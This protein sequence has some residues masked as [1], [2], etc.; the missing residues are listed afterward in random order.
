MSKSR[1]HVFIVEGEIDMPVRKLNING[2]TFYQ[3]GQSGKMY[4]KKED[5]EKQGYAIEAQGY[6]KKPKPKR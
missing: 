5:A 6:K 1:I 3:W 4:K 2:E